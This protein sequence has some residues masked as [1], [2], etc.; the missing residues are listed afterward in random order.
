[1]VIEWLSYRVPEADQPAFLA[2]DAAVWTAALSGCAGYGGKETWRRAEAPDRIDL[3]IRWETRDHWKAVP[4]PL[5]AET[6]ARFR[7]MFSGEAEFLGCTDLD[8]V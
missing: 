8:V 6:E 2:A 1:M 3:I 7:A 4:G 5:L